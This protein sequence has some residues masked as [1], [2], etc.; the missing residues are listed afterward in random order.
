MA[1]IGGMQ[2]QHARIERWTFYCL[3]FE[4]LASP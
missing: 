4:F 2:Q 3:S 1:D